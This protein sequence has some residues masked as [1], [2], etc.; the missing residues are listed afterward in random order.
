MTRRL[1]RDIPGHDWRVALPE[2][3]RCGFAA[4]F[5]EVAAPLPLVVE[6]G[7]GRGEFLL[8]LAS[9]SPHTAHLGVELSFRR[10]LKMA[11]RLAR[12]ELCN[13]RLVQGPAQR[14]VEDALSDASVACF[15]INFPDPW[16]KKR[17][18]RRRLLQPDFA[19]LLA[20]RL[21]PGGDLRVAT[22]DP[23]YALWIDAALRAQPELLN[24]HAPEP[25]APEECDRQPTA[26]ERAWRAQGRALHF[27]H[28]RRKA[29]PAGGR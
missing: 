24:L 29:R 28:Y 23:A 3:A 20:R 9:A 18:A 12:T 4:L 5:G 2:V 22:D 8:G 11:R 16:P 15:W 19:A 14:I 1:K 21:V 25:F 10:T 17:H 26:Y 27:F 13:V 7:Y 6:L